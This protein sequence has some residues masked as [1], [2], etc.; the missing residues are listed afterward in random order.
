MGEGNA[1]KLDFFRP[2]SSLMDGIF[3]KKGN[4]LAP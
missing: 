1:I 2:K 3:I 4:W